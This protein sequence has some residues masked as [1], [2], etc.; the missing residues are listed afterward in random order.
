M[1]Q[2][3]DNARLSMQGWWPWQKGH[4]AFSNPHLIGAPSCR[5]KISS[6]GRITQSWLTCCSSKTREQQSR[7]P[8][9]SPDAKGDLQK[10]PKSQSQWAAMLWRH[11]HQS[12]HHRALLHLH[13]REGTVHWEDTRPLLGQDENRTESTKV[14]IKVETYATLVGQAVTLVEQF[15][16]LEY[17]APAANNTHRW[18]EEQT[19][20]GCPRLMIKSTTDDCNTT[21]MMPRICCGWWTMKMVWLDNLQLHVATRCCSYCCQRCVEQCSQLG[22]EKHSEM[23]FRDCWILG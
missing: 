4:S 11:T 20:K 17:Q 10:P 5:K 8:Q 19:Q 15:R 1:R 21:L 23:S 16:K 22:N 12:N 7:D 18:Q 6:R 9:K 2:M 3:Q 14:S 13:D